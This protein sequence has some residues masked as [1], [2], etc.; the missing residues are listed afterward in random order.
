MTWVRFRKWR[1]VKKFALERLGTL[2][3]RW[4]MRRGDLRTRIL[5]GRLGSSGMIYRRESLGRGMKWNKAEVRLQ[6]RFRCVSGLS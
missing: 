6:N 4:P 5:R 2:Y 1:R 3:K